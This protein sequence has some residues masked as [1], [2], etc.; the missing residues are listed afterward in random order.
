VNSIGPFLAQRPA[1]SPPLSSRANR[2]GLRE[3]SD[4]K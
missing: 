2:R 4:I 1:N 3:V